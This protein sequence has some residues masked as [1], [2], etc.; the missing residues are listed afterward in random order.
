MKIAIFTDSLGLPRNTPEKVEYKNTWIY[1][2]GKEHEIFQVS[3]GG[4]TIIDLYNQT[5][6]LESFNPDIVLIQSGIV[7]CTPRALTK[8]ENHILN[9]YRITRKI[10]NIILKKKTIRFLRKYRNCNYT[11][12]STFLHYAN[13]FQ[14]HYK[15]SR[16]YFIGILPAADAYEN[17]IPG[18]KHNINLY[19]RGLKNIY[20]NN[21]LDTSDFGTNEI[22]SDYTHLND[23][24]NKALFNKICKIINLPQ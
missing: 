12:I 5:G 8:T 13:N 17:K 11:N 15:I 24:G 20:L 1:L 3:I 23:A 7:D 21:F 4:A 14:T 6:Y 18:V 9:K 19:N 16:V 10:L 22:M 2:L